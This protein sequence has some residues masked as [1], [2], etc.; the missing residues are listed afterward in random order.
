[1]KLLEGLTD[2]PKQ[3]TTIVLDDGTKATL[4]MEYRSQQLGWF[5]DLTWG[6]FVLNGVRL[7]ASP[8]ILRGYRNLIPFGISILTKG[9]VEPL[10]QSDFVDGTITAV[11]LDA[12]EVDEVEAAIFEGF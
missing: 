12:D 8:N 10:N 4:L 6:D 1:M 5:Y 7:V 2:Q 3:Q 11:L 9:A